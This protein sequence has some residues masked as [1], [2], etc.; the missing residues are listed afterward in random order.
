MSLPRRFARN[1]AR[2]RLRRRSSRSSGATTTTSCFRLTRK[3][4]GSTSGRRLPARSTARAWQH[5]LEATTAAG[6]EVARIARRRYA[7]HGVPFRA[8]ARRAPRTARPTDRHARPGPARRAPTAIA[9][10]KTAMAV[11]MDARRRADELLLRG[12]A[13]EEL[14]DPNPRRPHRRD[15]QPRRRAPANDPRRTARDSETSASRWYRLAWRE[16]DHYVA[17]SAATG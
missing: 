15:D 1:W 14:R 4:K 11:P 3:A 10:V 8:R 5:D 17:S 13:H 16:W 6:A 7:R 9:G 12:Q 2:C